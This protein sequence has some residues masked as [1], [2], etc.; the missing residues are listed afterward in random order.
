MLRLP[1]RL[2]TLLLW[3][4][5]ALLPVRGAATVLMPVLMGNAPATAASADDS[6]MPCHASPAMAADD[7]AGGAT[8]ACSLCDLCHSAAAQAPQAPSLPALAAGNAPPNFACAALEPRA[9]DGLFR[10]P[11]HAAA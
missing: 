7:T 1:R 2:V 8:H 4:G 5:I 11:R 3:L 10:P 9:P 6:A